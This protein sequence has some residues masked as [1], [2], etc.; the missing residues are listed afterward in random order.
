[1]IQLADFTRDGALS[2]GAS[3]MVMLETYPLDATTEEF[4]FDSLQALH[5]RYEKIVHGVS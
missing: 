4:A 2:L 1:M 3:I 5:A